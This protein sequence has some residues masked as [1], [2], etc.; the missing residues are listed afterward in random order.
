M[1]AFLTALSLGLIL[2][3][4]LVAIAI[5]SLRDYGETINAG[6]IAVIMVL[7]GAGALTNSVARAQR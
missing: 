4:F 1:K 7:L 5:G 6:D 2:M 3:A